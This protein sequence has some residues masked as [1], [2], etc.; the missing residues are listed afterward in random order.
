VQVA[1]GRRGPGGP[2]PAP[3]WAVPLPGSLDGAST[4]TAGHLATPPVPSPAAGPGIPRRLPAEPRGPARGSSLPALRSGAPPHRGTAQLGPVTLS[5]GRLAQVVVPMSGPHGQRTPALRAAG[6]RHR[7]PGRAASPEPARRSDVPPR[8]SARHPAPTGASAADL[9]RRRGPAPPLRP[10][11]D[12]CSGCGSCPTA[13]PCGGSGA[14]TSTRASPRSRRR[15]P[16]GA[17]P[18]GSAVPAWSRWT[19]PGCGSRTP[20]ATS[21]GGPSAA[22]GGGAG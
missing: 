1:V 3:G 19:R 17:A 9:P 4:R 13:R 18:A 20:R 7:A 11:A 6:D 10:P 16:W 22:A 5:K 2:P 21:S 15:R 8:Q 12:G 14:A